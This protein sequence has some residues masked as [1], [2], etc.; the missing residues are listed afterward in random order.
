MDGSS[1]ED[2]GLKVAVKTGAKKLVNETVKKVETLQ[3]SVTQAAGKK[4]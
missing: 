4:E 2:E 3:K 1:S